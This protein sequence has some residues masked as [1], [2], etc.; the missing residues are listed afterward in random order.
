MQGNKQLSIS[1][2]M[3][4]IVLSR[5]PFINAGYGS[6]EDAWG[7]RY[8]AE[9]I[10]RSGV[11]EVSRLPG[12]PLQE[13]I[14]SLI[15]QW[16]PLSFNLMTLLISSCGL[17]LFMLSLQELNIKQYTLAGLAVAFTPVIYINSMNAMDYM[18]ALSFIMTAF[19][20][21]IKNK[22]VAVGVFLGLAVG[23]RI[24]SGAM[25]IPFIF[26]LA[27]SENIK[28]SLQ[29]ITLMV[30]SLI[31]VAGTLYIPV[32]QV[33]GSTFFTYYEHFDIPS[34]VKNTYKGT[35][36][37]WGII[38]LLAMLFALGRSVT[39]FLKKYRGES[40]STNENK[41]TIFCL[42]VL[43]LYIISFGR[44]PLKAAFMIPVIPFLILFIFQ[45]IKPQT[46]IFLSIA[47][48]ISC[49]SLG[50][51]LSD[52][53]RGS[54]ESSFAY[55]MK[56]AGQLVSID[57]FI[58]PVIADYSKQERM[59]HFAEEVLE[60]TDKLKS[61]SVIISG[62]YLNFIR[63]LSGNKKSI[64][65]FVYYVDEYEIREYIKK[66]NRVYYLPLQDEYNDLRFKSRFT[67]NYSLPLME[68][69]SLQMP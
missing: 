28:T 37:V 62:W 19:Y 51:N 69:T 6:E 5:I 21:L 23:C 30:L 67:N 8:T 58:G 31:I 63:V 66:G 26:Y 57:P 3:L 41:L 44:L 16:G 42:L 17:F 24:T 20:F 13:I 40:F 49:F 53:N 61:P 59:I 55:R 39:N 47:M 65:Q 48:I 10:S 22:P 25:I 43:A 14:Y 32:V 11:Y 2:S 1:L 15:W 34:F 50:I 18:W 35:I 46:A 36:G 27:D 68:A 54:I 12:H 4:L 29:Q 7:L 33:Y 60:K 52:T 9:Q 38:G 45:F 64:H 56:I